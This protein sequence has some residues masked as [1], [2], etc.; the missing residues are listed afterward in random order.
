[1]HRKTEGEMTM[2]RTHELKIWPEFFELVKSG[3][4]MFEVR[5]NDRDFR[6]GDTLVL[7]EYDPW[8]LRYTGREI[9]RKIS[10]ILDDPR[11]CKAG[12]VILGFETGE[13]KRAR[14]EILGEGDEFGN[15]WHL[16]SNCKNGHRHLVLA[17]VP[18]C[19][20]CGAMME[21]RTL[22]EIEEIVAE[23]DRLGVTYGKYVLM[24]EQERDRKEAEQEKK[25]VKVKPR[26][27]R[28]TSRRDAD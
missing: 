16:C 5:E 20:M 3:A 2:G 10:C 8:M 14:W 6:V 22:K 11:F 18:Y 15:A 13:R 26:K 24:M 7:K 27:I 17:N 28:K 21:V 23:A 12:L 9:D 4:K 25:G 19:W 1:M